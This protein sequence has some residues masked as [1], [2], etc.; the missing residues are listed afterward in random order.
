VTLLSLLLLF[1]F[2]NCAPCPGAYTQAPNG[3]DCFKIKWYWN[4][5]IGQYYPPMSYDQMDNECNNAGTTTVTGGML[6]SIH[7][8]EENANVLTLMQTANGYCGGIST[9]IGL[10]CTGKYCRWDDGSPVTYTNFGIEPYDGGK[11]RCYGVQYGI[12]TWNP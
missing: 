10:R 4:T 12:L 3:G 6:A 7:S 11:T 2:S 9:N 5:F 8:A 1:T